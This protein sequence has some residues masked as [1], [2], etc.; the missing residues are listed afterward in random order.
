MNKI[1][2]G[3]LIIS[4]GYKVTRA[5]PEHP[6]LARKIM[7]ITNYHARETTYLN[8][9]NHEWGTYLTG[10]PN[11]MWLYRGEEVILVKLSDDYTLHQMYLVIYNGGVVHIVVDGESVLHKNGKW[12]RIV[13]RM[14]REIQ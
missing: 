3:I 13:E 2:L 7:N 1:I 8:E 5:N 9:F 4:I 6:T 11:R 14:W 12:K 10:V